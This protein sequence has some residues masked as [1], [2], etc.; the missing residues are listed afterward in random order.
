[1]KTHQLLLS[2]GAFALVG[3][4]CG[5]DTMSMSDEVE[6]LTSHQAA[7]EADLAGHHRDVLEA[8]DMAR[9]RSLETGFGQAS[10]GHMDEMDHRMRDMQGMCSMGGHNFD[11]GSMVDTMGR[12]RIGLGEHHRRMGATNDLDALR[13]EEGAFRDMMTTLMAEMRGRQSAIRGTAA[14]YSCRMHGH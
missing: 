8:A 6:G 9:V 2:I 14:Q 4:A 10:L 7:L 1:M 12:A 5:K 3:A 13:L 11:G